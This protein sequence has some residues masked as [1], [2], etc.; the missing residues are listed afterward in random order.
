MVLAVFLAVC[1]GFTGWVFPILQYRAAFNFVTENATSLHLKERD[2]NW[3]TKLLWGPEILV[4]VSLEDV[5]EDDLKF[6]RELDTIESLDLMGLGVIDESIQNL[7]GMEQLE[8]L[9]LV[10]TRVSGAG[11]DRLG[12]SIRRLGI[13]DSPVDD[14][15]ME[16]I[17][18]LKKLTHLDVESTL[19]TDTGCRNL[20]SLTQLETLSILGSPL[21]DQVMPA[22]GALKHMTHLS[23][24]D[25]R[26]TDVG[27]R[28]LR[29][30]PI[31]KLSLFNCHAVA[32]SG[33]DAMNSLRILNL[34]GSALNDETAS[35]L[36]SLSQVEYLYLDKTQIT[37]AAVESFCRMP[38]LRYLNISRT[39]VG[40]R[41]VKLL[42]Q[43]SAIELI[44]CEGLKVSQQTKQEL[45]S[46]RFA[47]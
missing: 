5:D 29:G 11:L 3:L 41:G 30:L 8:S 46:S 7:E 37:D 47:F 16:S 34:D 27:L 44:E 40:D 9:G 6:L 45:D 43:K 38:S 31:E 1:I 15:G 24:W 10:S 35:S 2:A 13:Y 25:A 18:R 21:T 26:I 33:L 22:I 12:Q 19:L 28:Q 20:G 17:C 36:E 23:L 4:N 39:R 42:S 32:G 14:R